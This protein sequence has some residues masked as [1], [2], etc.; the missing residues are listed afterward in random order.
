MPFQMEN[1]TDRAAADDLFELAH[2]RKPALVQSSCK[3]DVRATARIDNP[4]SVIAPKRER[5]LAPDMLACLRRRDRLAHMQRMGS[6]Q[7]NRSNLRI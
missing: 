3:D 6:G 7:K 1:L 4:L 2:G 5:L